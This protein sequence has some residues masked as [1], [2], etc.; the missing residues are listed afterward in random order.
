MMVSISRDYR[1][2][3]VCLLKL[4]YILLCTNV[5][6][7]LIEM[8]LQLK[9]KTKCMRVLLHRSL[10]EANFST[11]VVK[12]FSCSPQQILYHNL[13]VIGIN[14]SSHTQINHE[15]FPRVFWK[16]HNCRVLGIFLCHK[17]HRNIVREY[18][19]ALQ[20]YVWSSHVCYAALA[21]QF[22]SVICRWR[23]NDC[24]SKFK[25]ES[26]L[27]K[28]KSFQNQTRIIFVKI[29]TFFFIIANTNHEI[30]YVHHPQWD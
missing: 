11:S 27:S 26:S 8:S 5:F 1:L 24:F 7:K 22:V 17:G 10:P 13:L 12:L 29:K 18:V 4:V 23:D 21:M 3:Y 14:R 20:W 9:S 6:H 25:Q 2:F 19:H 30:D 16:R 28:S 15:V